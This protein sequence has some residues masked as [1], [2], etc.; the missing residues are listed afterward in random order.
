VAPA[1]AK[2]LRVLLFLPGGNRTQG[3]REML[4]ARE[5]G[6]LLTGEA[7]YQLH[8][9]YL[10]YE[11]DPARARD[12]L[13]GLD[14]RYPSNPIFLSRIAQIE[15]DYF[16]DHAASAEAWQSLL[17]RADA[18][19]IENSTIAEMTARL[20]LGAELVELDRADRAI[21]QLDIVAARRPA[22]PYSAQATA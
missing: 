8:W 21:E 3:L 17:D 7:D 4:Q 15:A 11:H 6:E 13:R 20:G 2:L 5:H 9:V 10:W 14:R 1:A 22:A 19:R 12:L 16:H 18:H